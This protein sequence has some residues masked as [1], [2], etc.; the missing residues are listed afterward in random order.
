MTHRPARQKPVRSVPRSNLRDQ[1]G[2][3][4]RLPCERMA[5]ALLPVTTDLVMR[6]NV[7]TTTTTTTLSTCRRSAKPAAYRWCRSVK[8]NY[9]P[10]QGMQLS[11]LHGVTICR[12]DLTFPR[13]CSLTNRNGSL[14]ST[15]SRGRPSETCSDMAAMTS[16]SICSML[17]RRRER[18]L[19]K[20]KEQT[21]K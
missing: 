19:R 5:R 15:R 10:Y 17:P 21:T 9:T 7:R 16:V 12:D 1:C 8:M 3:Q 4:E 6:V 2:H 20:M 18:L 13:K 11:N 14:D